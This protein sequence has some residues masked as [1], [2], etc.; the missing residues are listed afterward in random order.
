MIAGA[1]VCAGVVL[2]VSAIAG[3]SDSDIS[4]A[5]L[6][7]GFPTA[8]PVV[9]RVQASD[10]ID[11][12]HPVWRLTVTGKD[13]VAAAQALLAAGFDPIT[14]RTPVDAGEVGALY[15]GHGFTVGLSSDGDTVTYV[16]SPTGA[17]TPSSGAA[18][19]SP[20]AAG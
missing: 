13:T 14:P 12:G 10:D 20:V 1:A 16:V 15:L 11:V 9:G 2:S 8:V 3:C 17:A 4:T 5:S 7:S 18:P 19:S 6:P